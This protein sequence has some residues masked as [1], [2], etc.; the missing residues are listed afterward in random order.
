MQ[1]LR[2]LLFRVPALQYV[3]PRSLPVTSIV[4]SVEEYDERESSF[5]GSGIQMCRTEVRICTRRNT[6]GHDS[7]DDRLNEGQRRVLGYGWGRPGRK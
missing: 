6:L 1:V 3:L 2:L 5:L 4:P 7:E